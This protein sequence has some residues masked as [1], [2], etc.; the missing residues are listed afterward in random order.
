MIISC[1]SCKTKYTV[2]AQSLGAIGRIVKCTKCGNKWHQEAASTFAHDGTQFETPRPEPQPQPTSQAEPQPEPTPRPRRTAQTSEHIPPFSPK[3]LPALATTSQPQNLWPGIMLGIAATVGMIGAAVMLKDPII[4]AIPAMQLAFKG[5]NTP[6]QF[7]A[8]YAK[9]PGL[10]IE[11]I[12]RDILEDDGFTTY[13]I[14]G[15]VTNANLSEQAVPNLVVSLLDEH[16]NALDSWKVEP[17]KR[18][19][20]AGESTAWICYFYNPPLAK[21][22]EYKVTFAVQP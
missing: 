17:Q 2:P 8:S 22:S 14:Q 18:I 20:Q 5:T 12:E 9:A 3:H 11:K 6:T 15:L 16:G 7:D 10:V 19:L 21:V 1:P 4:R 13:V